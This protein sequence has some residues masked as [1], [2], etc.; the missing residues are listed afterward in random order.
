[1]KI[2]TNIIRNLFVYLIPI[3]MVLSQFRMYGFDSHN[4]LDYI[5]TILLGFKGF[6]LLIKSVSAEVP[7][8]FAIFLTYCLLTFVAYVINGVPIR[9]YYLAL[10]SFIIPALF[11]YFGYSYCNDESFNKMFMYGSMFCFIIGFYYHFS[12]NPTYLNMLVEKSSDS[13]NA[14]GGL[15]SDNVLDFVRFGSFFGN[16]YYIEFFS[17]PSLI[18]SL[19]YINSGKI[20]NRILYIV[21]LVSFIAALLSIQRIAVG[22]AF[23]VPAL[24]LLAN[25]PRKLFRNLL[26]ILVLLIIVFIPLYHYISSNAVF[27]S[28]NEQFSTMMERFSISGAMDERKY[29]YQTFDRA[30]ALSY[31]F[32]LGLG[33]CGHNAH[34]L[35]I[36]SVNDNEYMH[37]FY[38]FGILGSLLLLYPLLKT[39]F[40]GVQYRKIYKA[41]LLIIIYYLAASLGCD[42]TDI[43]YCSFIFWFSLGRIWNK[44]YFQL[45]MIEN[46]QNYI[47]QQT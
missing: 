38:E 18:L 26:L 31:I 17:I 3:I 30:T 25:D 5:F 27:E 10:L 32:G 19:S 20:D 9:C 23:L 11:F 39:I 40:R 16:S 43:T 2:K 1:M 7:R 14:N 34:M 24:Y 13:L 22:F 33:S 35:G 4:Y 46:S 41:E 12:G 42:P 8:L 44:E 6:Q 28:L 15:N 45:R 29:Q 21:A 36:Q 37:L 47:R